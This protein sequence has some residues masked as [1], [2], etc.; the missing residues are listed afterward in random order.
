MDVL[1]RGLPDE[2]HAELVR[3]AAE[4]DMSVRAYVAKV[5]GDHVAVPS[6]AEWLE[7]V[8]ALG[9]VETEGRTGAELV[10]E[11]RAAD[12]RLVGR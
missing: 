12:E 3:R 2:V 11:A 5:L 6:M 1:I 10:A 4:A 8:R 9:D 7:R